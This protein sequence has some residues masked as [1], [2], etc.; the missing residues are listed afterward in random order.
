MPRQAGW[1]LIGHAL[2]WPASRD[3]SAPLR[4]GMV[5]ALRLCLPVRSLAQPKSDL[6]LTILEL[7]THINWDELSDGPDSECSQA[8]TLTGD[9]VEIFLSRDFVPESQTRSAL[10]SNHLLTG[11]IRLQDMDKHHVHLSYYLLR[12]GL[13]SAGYQCRVA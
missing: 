4:L 6:I 13:A 2:A 3:E 9:C 10:R 12:Q 7:G 5:S 11:A 1:V 8:H